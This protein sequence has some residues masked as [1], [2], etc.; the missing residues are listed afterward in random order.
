MSEQD[1]GGLEERPLSRLPQGVMPRPEVEERI[2]AA[3]R[4]RGAIRSASARWP[5]RLAAAAAAVVLLA[6]GFGLGRGA[7]LGSRNRDEGPR[8]ALFL[9]RGEQRLPEKPDE[10]AGRVAEYRAWARGLAGGGR[11]V[12]GEKL[13][14]RAQRLGATAGASGGAAPEQEIRGF[15][16]VGASSFEEALAIART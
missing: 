9:L 8:Y 1:E 15:F 13:E 11:F 7:A 10:E 2:V 16:I 5:R 12:S 14:D 6:A 4:A 3:L